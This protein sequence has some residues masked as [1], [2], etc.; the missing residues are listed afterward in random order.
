MSAIWGV[1]A[2]DDSIPVDAVEKNMRAA[3]GK[4]VIDRTEYYVGNRIAMGCGIQYFT[5]EAEKEVLPIIDVEE[6]IYF[7]ADVVLDNREELLKKLGYESDDKSIPDGRILYEVFKKYKEDCLN[8]LLGVYSFVYYERRSNRCYLVTDVASRRSLHYFIQDGTLYYS[9]LIDPIIAA[10]GE[11]KLNER[12]FA[13]F[14]ALD[15]L[16]MAIVYDETPYCGICRV[17]ASHVMVWDGERIT[18]T[19]Y[20]NPEVKNLK[21]KSDEEYKRLFK[22]T[23]N[24]SIRCRMRNKKTAISLSAGLDST[25]IVC[26]AA[27]IAHKEQKEIITY[28]SVPE[29]PV[30]DKVSDY[31]ITDE[32]AA[33]QQ[34]KAFLEEK[35]YQIECKFLNLQGKNSWDERKRE[36][37][38]ME[39]PYK[40]MQNLLWMREIEEQAY[41]DDVRIILSGG[42]GN[43]TISADFTNVYM[44]ELIQGFHYIK[45][46]KEITSIK[47]N[48]KIPRK[49]M[50]KTAVR[51]IRMSYSKRPQYDFQSETKNSLLSEQMMDKH[52]IRERFEKEFAYKM[53]LDFDSSVSKGLMENKGSFYQ[54][55]ETATKHSLATGILRRDPTMDKRVIELCMSY[56]AE[57]YAKNGISRRLVREYLSEE[58]PDHITKTYH[59]GLQSADTVVRVK[60]QGN[61]IFDEIREVF[62]RWTDTR[63]VN[64]DKALDMLENVREKTDVLSNFELLRLEYSALVLEYIENG[65]ADGK[66]KK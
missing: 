10:T 3:Y 29:F 26:L 54:T 19:K 6:G 40:S 15:S 32:E 24:E 45:L 8:D 30:Q 31:Y 9:T 41:Q 5:P 28:T 53:N 57:Q 37:A 38:I 65:N 59:Q 14:L 25:S 17:L 43:I 4:C 23:Y 46:M 50:I 13:D 47:R 52:H 36:L 42:H 64:T 34:T 7:D 58:M 55:G 39:I 21:L 20:W 66:L 35:G 60:K 12:W 2:K 63:L 56:P 11:K 1:I 18:E 51:A 44:N 61:R 33:V 16:V 62:N 22:K 49:K 27:N 48:F